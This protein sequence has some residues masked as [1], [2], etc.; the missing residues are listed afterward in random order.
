METLVRITDAHRGFYTRKDDRLYIEAV[1]ELERDTLI[2]K[3]MALEKCSKLSKKIVRYVARTLEPV[4]INNDNQHEIFAKDTYMEKSGA[5]SI[6][7]VPL[8]HRGISIGVLYLEN[9]TQEGAF[10]GRH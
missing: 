6:A 8:K 7:C 10:I 3:P 4:I 5:K 9:T 1:I 2:S